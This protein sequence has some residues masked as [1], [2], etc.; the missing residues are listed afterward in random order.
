MDHLH[1]RPT[2]LG[3]GARHA[4]L[5]GCNHA[6]HTGLSTLKSPE[7]ELTRLAEILQNRETC[8]FD[9]ITLLLGDEAQKK[10]IQNTLKQCVKNLGA[11]DTLVVVWSGHG[12]AFPHAG[13]TDLALI[14]VDTHIDAATK[15]I[16]EKTALFGEWFS[17]HVFLAPHVGHILLI[18]NCCY[19]ASGIHSSG[20]TTLFNT[21]HL[22]SREAKTRWVMAASSSEQ[23]AREIGEES[24][25]LRWVI[26]TLANGLLTPDGRLHPHDV[27]SQVK[28]HMGSHDQGPMQV[29]AGR[30]DT[31]VLG[32]YQN[33]CMFRAGD[34]EHAYVQNQQVIVE[35]QRQMAWE[36]FDLLPLDI[37]PPI[38]PI[39][40]GSRTK[41]SPNPHFVGRNAVLLSLARDLK[42]GA[43]GVLVPIA[44]ATGLGG[45][46]KTSVAVEFA[47][48]YGA[49]FAG[50]VFWLS[51][52]DP[53]AIPSEIAACGG[54]RGLN[55]QS[56]FSDLT[57]DKQVEHVQDA[58]E[59]DIPRLLIFDNCQDPLVVEKWRPTTG[60]CR[61]LITSRRPDWPSSLQIAAVRLDVLPRIS[62]IELLQQL[63]PRL[64]PEEAVAIATELGDL[65]LALHL[66]GSFLARYAG[67]VVPTYLMQLQDK[68][69]LYHPCFQGRG[70]NLS[71]T[72][73]E[74]SVGR[75]FALSYDQLNAVDLIDRLAQQL[76]ATLRWLA[77][78]EPVPRDLLMNAL[79]LPPDDFDGADAI[80]RIAELGLV[81][82]YDDG[83]LAIHR[84]VQSFV[85][86]EVKDAVALDVVQ[87]MLNARAVTVIKAGYPAAMQPL[88]A[89]LRWMTRLA[90]SR[91]D[92]AMAALCNTLGSYL[93]ATGDYGAARPLY[94]R[95]LAIREQALGPDHP[96]TSAS[97]NNL[98][99]LLQSTGDY[100]GARP[101]FER[102]L[103]IGEQT[104][105]PDHPATAR[106]LNNLASLL[107]AT[108]DYVGA[109]PLYERA[110]AI[111]EQVQGP[112]HP[113]T[114]QSLNNLAGLLQSM[115]NSSGA[116]P[117]LERALAI[118]EQTLGT[119]HPTIGLSLNNLARLLSA[120]GDY[121]A[122]RPLYERALAIN[123]TALGP[124]HPNTA[125]SLNNLASLLKSMGDY[126][127]AQPLME[128]ALVIREQ[129]LGPTHPDT[130]R[131]LHSLASLLEFM[132]DYKA[133]QPLLKRALT[134]LEQTLGPDH[135][136]TATSLN[137][138]AMLLKSMGDYRA[139]R[140]LLERVLTIREQVLGPD[141]PD[142][143]QS[144][145]NLAYLLESTEQFGAAWPLYERAL[146][147]CEK[148]LGPDHPDTAQSLTNLASLLQATGHY[149]AARPLFERVLAIYETVLGP[150]HV[151]TATSLNN[152]AMLLYTMGEYSAARPLFER[153]LAIQE[154]EL[155]PDHPDTATSLNNLAYLLYAMGDYVRVR[156]LFERALAIREQA[157]GP[158][159]PDTASVRRNLL[160]LD[161]A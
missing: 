21:K 129:A 70:S 141:H 64:T 91:E 158:N 95:A 121:G 98:A 1:Q 14:T 45:I 65:P 113:D 90:A 101:L 59:R 150:N 17:Q 102:A 92:E 29:N 57:V 12:E 117:L 37:L 68:E 28:R 143:A 48:R 140:P 77:P 9:E 35:R 96:S 41:H 109:R 105:G 40:T 122:A 72:A 78:G 69:L 152:L 55:I 34:L 106:S 130:A 119:D 149:R 85:Q 16:V 44:A 19:A 144:L 43:Q 8:A 67:L 161:G 11:E 24:V 124:D 49:Y 94:E 27:W 99:L 83:S 100:V 6:P 118:H 32:W 51:C 13:F 80:I 153:A 86:T 39:P 22:I 38:S 146:A 111:N 155:R 157:L 10:D 50:G 147:I 154:T 87:N 56:G 136:A 93:S 127:A 115:G 151:T 139:A 60:G 82:P 116:R 104:L 18:F 148:V 62:S 74:L 76:L 20:L 52:E 131:S 7:T 15:E 97:L 61:V 156:P 110:L 63:A 54:P 47:H 66:A 145:N 159:H 42:G 107:D 4:V 125:L 2:E 88:L 120:T 71:P 3:H 137:N 89:H 30:L 53:E 84:L 23:K 128:R 46:G 142:T 33:Q 103:A 138:L 112:T 114:A 31:M 79:T 160:Q 26:H 25:F 133:A 123:E 81:E 134:I 126:R 58:W 73:H 135:P 132:G 108:G 36:R 75:T 5:I